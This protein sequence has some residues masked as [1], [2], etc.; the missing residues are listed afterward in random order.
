MGDLMPVGEGD[1]L[2]NGGKAEGQG[3]V[4]EPKKRRRRWD[5]ARKFN[6]DD[7]FGIGA[8]GDRAH[9][10]GLHKT[11][12]PVRARVWWPSHGNPHLGKHF[13]TRGQRR[14]VLI[15]RGLEDGHRGICDALIA[16][17]E[18]R[19]GPQPIKRHGL[20]VRSSLRLVLLRI[21]RSVSAPV[22]TGAF[23]R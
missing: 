4:F 21:H 20:Y 5:V 12:R 16:F 2:S 13:P 19:P 8:L 11:G 6:V 22:S 10:V 1:R 17:E 23:G 7:G 15:E 3:S 9:I 14:C 18:K